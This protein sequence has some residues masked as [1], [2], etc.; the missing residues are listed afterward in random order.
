MGLSAQVIHLLALPIYLLIAIK[1]HEVTSS[2]TA[3]E[4]KA[5]QSSAGSA[6][7][8][9]PPP[10]AGPGREKQGQEWEQRLGEGKTPRKASKFS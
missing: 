1:I 7:L 4:T 8:P 2:S 9:S 5:S 3:Q 10:A 6:E